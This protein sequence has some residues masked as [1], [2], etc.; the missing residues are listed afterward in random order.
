MV[1]W[2]LSRHT[3]ELPWESVTNAWWQKYPNQHSLQVTEVDTIDRRMDRN[4]GELITRRLISAHLNP[5]SWMAAIGFPNYCYVLEET[6]VNPHS[7][8]MVLKSVN[9]T[10]SDL[11]QIQETCEYKSIENDARCLYEQSAAITSFVPLVHSAVE[12]YSLGIHSGNASK[13]LKAMEE[14]CEKYVK[15]GQEGFDE[16]LNLRLDTIKLMAD[17]QTLRN[18]DMAEFRN[19][20]FV[21]WTSQF[22]KELFQSAHLSAN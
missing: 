4:T 10:G 5:P 14:L 11:L 19:L 16:I 20:P 17:L 12:S 3:F 6:R 9:V 18:F 13:G 2:F 1:K 22:T 15:L 8:H 7:K 21:K